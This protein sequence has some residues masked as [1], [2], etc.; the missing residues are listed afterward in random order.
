M[1][2]ETAWLAALAPHQKK[3]TPLKD[4]MIPEDAKPRRRRQSWQE[5]KAGLVLALGAP[6][7]TRH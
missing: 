5:I 3:P 6:P 4:L 7:D 2:M 1:M